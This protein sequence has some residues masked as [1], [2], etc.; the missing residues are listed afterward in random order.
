MPSPT[1][2]DL[3]GGNI[4]AAYTTA[5]VISPDDT[6]NLQ[7]LPKSIYVGAAGNIRLLTISDVEVIFMAV[8]VGTILPFRAKK[9]FLTGTTAGALLGLN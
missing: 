6:A 4:T 3:S 1:P 5:F 9:V 7:A 2:P 8:P